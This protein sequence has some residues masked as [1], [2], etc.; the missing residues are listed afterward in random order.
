M[1]NFSPI[2]NEFIVLSSFDF[3]EATEI[4]AAVHLR[5]IQLNEGKRECYHS[6][7]LHSKMIPNLHQLTS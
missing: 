6:I 7:N 5:Q 4:H 1:W 2:S 3:F